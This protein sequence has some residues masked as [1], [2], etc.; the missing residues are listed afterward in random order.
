MLLLLHAVGFLAWGGII[1][2][3]LRRAE[4]FAAARDKRIPRTPLP[5]IL[6][7]AL[8]TIDT[9]APDYALLACAAAVVWHGLNFTTNFTTS[10]VICLLVG[11]FGRRLSASSPF[12]LI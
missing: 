9:Y 12:R 3:G 6:H 5:D 2:Y 4:A 7:D 8:P 1:S 11:P 10:D